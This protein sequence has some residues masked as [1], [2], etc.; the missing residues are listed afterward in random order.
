MAWRDYRD[1]FRQ[2]EVDMHRFIEESS[3]LDHSLSMS[4]FW[5]PAADV[6]ET[7][8]GMIVKLELAG[9][10]VSDVQVSLSGDGRIL[11]ISGSRSEQ[12]D[13]RAKRVSCHQLE[14][15]FGPFERTFSI[16]SDMDIERDGI[17]A[18]LKDGFLTITL[19]RRQR[20]P[21]Q[22]RTIPIEVVEEQ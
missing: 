4:R 11:S 3:F 12:G 19:P 22:T 16:P 7:E 13:E 15:Y 6:H 17:T 10:T 14:I 1:L 9:V 2:M 8:A 20:T 18:T 21:A 5:Q